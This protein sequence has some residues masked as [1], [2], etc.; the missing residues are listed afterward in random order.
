MTDR[1][2]QTKWVM[3]KERV[4]KIM[5]LCSLKVWKHTFKNWFKNDFSLINSYLCND[6]RC[7]GS[8][9]YLIKKILCLPQRMVYLSPVCCC[10]QKK[11]NWNFKIFPYKKSSYKITKLWSKNYLKDKNVPDHPWGLRWIVCIIRG[12]ADW[13]KSRVTSQRL[14]LCFIRLCLKRTHLKEEK[15]V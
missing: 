7:K 11:L 1:W 3:I 4:W 14:H 10:P 5:H 9:F 6:T 15:Y 13:K 2:V 12:T 8:S